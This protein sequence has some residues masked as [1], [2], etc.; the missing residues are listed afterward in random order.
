MTAPKPP[1][2]AAVRDLLKRLFKWQHSNGYTQARTAQQFLLEYHKS[3][4]RHP[5][6]SP[7]SI[8]AFAM[9]YAF[10]ALSVISRPARVRAIR[11]LHVLRSH[12]TS[13][14]Q[15]LIELDTQNAR[16]NFASKGPTFSD[17]GNDLLADVE[18]ISQKLVFIQGVDAPITSASWSGFVGETAARL[19]A[20][21]MA[22]DEVTA[23][24]Q[25]ATRATTKASLLRQTSRWSA[26][27]ARNRA[28]QKKS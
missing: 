4:A 26:A 28:S 9:K 3:N 14:Q 12:C 16:E 6:G 15:D 27:A 19:R 7:P 25:G 1:D 18:A 2:L 23:L 24:L 5:K 20:A 22:T 17:F 8:V 13:L 21:G 11:K 10:A